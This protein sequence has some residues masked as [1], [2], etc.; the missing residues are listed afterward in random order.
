MPAEDGAERPNISHVP[1]ATAMA[2]DAATT[3]SHA[4]R[5]RPR[6]TVTGLVTA[7][8]VVTVSRTART[9]LACW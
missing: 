4:F 5:G 6:D 3:P 1:T 7:D 9:S 8:R 2:T